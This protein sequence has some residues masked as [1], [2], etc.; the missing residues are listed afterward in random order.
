M[1]K[2]KRGRSSKAT[3]AQRLDLVGIFALFF[4]LLS[5]LG[6]YADLAGPA[7]RGLA[8]LWEWVFGAAAIAV[9][10]ALAWFG[11]F[12]LRHGEKE[13]PGRL[14]IGLLLTL[15]GIAALRHIAAAEQ[16]SGL[17]LE[18]MPR[19]GGIVGGLLG[20]PLV[21]ALSIWG[22]GIMVVMLLVMGALITTKTPV[23]RV[24]ALLGK[25]M[26]TLG[27][28]V[29]KTAAVV[30]P[31]ARKGFGAASSGTGAAIGRMKRRRESSPTS[32]SDEVDDTNVVEDAE[33]ED[34]MI[35]I[36]PEVAQ[37]ASLPVSLP[38]PTIA[39]EQPSRSY[40]L[41][42]IDFLPATPPGSISKRAIEETM[43]ILERTLSQ[44]GVDAS[45]TGYTP[46][47]TVTR[48]EVELGP[49]VKVN[50]VVSLQN[51]IRYALA[52][53]D[54]R[55]LAPIPGRS[56][57]GIEVPNRDRQLVSIGDV[58]RS[59]QA[60]TE[61]H[62]L[63]VALG[64]DISGSAIMVNLA[65]MPH[66]LIAGATGSGKSSCINAMITSILMRARPE[67]VRMILIDPKR[68][69][70]SH[71]NDVPHLLSPVVTSPKK[72]SEALGWVVREMEARYEL[73]ASVGMRNS[74]LYNEA[75]RTG[76][77]PPQWDDGMPRLPFPYYLVVI[78]ELADLMMVA[79]REVESSI[80]RIAQMA[81]AVG[82]HLVVATQRPSVDVV[83]GVIKAN[84][85]SRLAFATAS[86]ADSRVILDEGGAD[87]LVGRGDLL[88]KHAS[89][90][91]TQRIQGAW[92][93]ER[94]IE[95]V[96][97]WC[98]RQRRAEYIEGIVT[99]TLAGEMTT[100]D[101]GSADDDEQLMLEALELVVRSQLGS[102]SMLQRKLRVGFARAGRLMDL[103][104]QRG[105][106]GPSQGSKPRDVLMT[107]D[108]L[109]EMHL[110]D[111]EP[112]EPA[113]V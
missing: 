19:L 43:A 20:W 89:A 22:A 59:T 52:S 96:T 21:Q 112:S 69:E 102:T 10:V 74:D 70:L 1:S 98:R 2:R 65:D 54:L 67:Q 36:T 95:Q 49:A 27:R 81:R 44:F 79:P 97:A 39:P 30:A 111:Q 75:V 113:S 33:L 87:R 5:G 91:R 38:A 41:P 57:I 37:Q 26:S 109:E 82:I 99:D 56:A 106:V 40:R 31:A 104:E 71:Y 7:G 48:Y 94:E 62:A 11:I 73:L 15:S 29:G 24:V 34:E 100:G 60:K 47:P 35:P 14:A 9:P 84:I 68:V 23:A 42:S 66:L 25:A 76:A 107:A 103:L 45:V 92:V 90:P 51:E 88:Y 61:K 17:A 86:A 53:G 105:V 78:D 58:L 83:T 77:L 46:G 8:A 13:R 16:T 4:A 108:E 28:S 32:A 110:R 12:V 85:P 93:S 50:R 64:K 72:A 63:T 101:Y 80:C 3:A 55:L 6:I 18:D